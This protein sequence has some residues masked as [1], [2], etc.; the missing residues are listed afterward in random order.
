MKYN[1]DLLMNKDTKIIAFSGKKQSGKNTC[2]NFI[3]SL[4]LS[5]FEICNEIEINKYGQIVM[6]DIFGKTEYAGIFDPSNIDG[7]DF[8]LKSLKEKMDHIVQLYAFAD[9][10]KKDICMN[11]L[12]LSYDQCYGSDDQKNSITELEWND[13][14][15][16][17]REAMQILGTDIFRKMKNDVWTSSLLRKITQDN[18]KLAI[19]TDCRFPNEVDAIHKNNGIVIRLDRNSKV[20]DHISENILDEDKYDW[21]NFDYVIKNNNMSIYEQS[22]EIEK[23]LEEVLS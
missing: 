22:L 23:I 15:I 6:S 11:V 14:K 10:L 1:Q 2:A 12:G 3:Y 20:S 17:A 13:T 19:I 18:P 21:E 16:T 4:Y 9:I 7:E 8:I 5:K